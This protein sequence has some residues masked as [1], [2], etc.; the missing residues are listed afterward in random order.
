MRPREVPCVYRLAALAWHRLVVWVRATGRAVSDADESLHRRSN[1]GEYAGGLRG[2]GAAL[3]GGVFC[4]GRPGR[5]HV[6]AVL[7]IVFIRPFWSTSW[8]ELGVTRRDSTRGCELWK[9]RMKAF[10]RPMVWLSC[11]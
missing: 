1:P 2:A 4:C 8:L 6:S 9:Q 11:S 10:L 7:T 3:A 5:G